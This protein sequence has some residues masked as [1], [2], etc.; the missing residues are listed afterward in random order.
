M[1]ASTVCVVFLL[2]PATFGV[3][4]VQREENLFSLPLV[5][6]AASSTWRVVFYSS[7][8]PRRYRYTDARCRCTTALRC[9]CTASR[10]RCTAASSR[11][12]R[13]SVVQSSL[14]P[15]IS[16][17]TL[18][19][20]G[21][22]DDAPR[23][24]P[25]PS[26]ASSGFRAANGHCVFFPPSRTLNIDYLSFSRVDDAPLSDLQLSPLLRF[27]RCQQRLAVG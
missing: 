27:S 3:C 5:A 24:F 13:G 1:T 12:R 15:R 22:K 26:R 8:S 11:W 9:R 19:L 7:W 2:F 16:T 17:A 18:V 4:V 25:A 23:D 20:D 10:C 14:D 21:E 6:M